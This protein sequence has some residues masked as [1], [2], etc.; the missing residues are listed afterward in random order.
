MSGSLRKSQE[1]TFV[2]SECFDVA[3]GENDQFVLLQTFQDFDQGSNLCEELADGQPAS[4][5]SEEEFELIIGFLETNLQ[6]SS[7]QRETND[8]VYIG[9]ISESN[10]VRPRTEDDV[11]R[12]SWI[13][14]SD[15][16][17]GTV[18]GESPWNIGEPNNFQGNNADG[19][20]G[21]QEGE[22]CVIILTKDLRWN[23]I[24]CSKQKQML[25]RRSCAVRELP[26]IPDSTMEGEGFPGGLIFLILLMIA[27]VMAAILIV[28]RAKKNRSGNSGLGNR[29]EIN[30]QFPRDDPSLPHQNGFKGKGNQVPSGLILPPESRDGQTKRSWMRKLVDT[31]TLS[32]MKPISGHENSTVSDAETRE[33][34][35]NSYVN[36]GNSFSHVPS[37][38]FSNRG[39]FFSILTFNTGSASGQNQQGEMEIGDPKFKGVSKFNHQVY[40]KNLRS[41]NNLKKK[42]PK[43]LRRARQSREFIDFKV[44]DSVAVRSARE[45]FKQLQEEEQRKQGNQSQGLTSSQQLPCLNQKHR[46]DNTNLTLTSSTI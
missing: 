37:T 23:D 21:N 8:G 14:G 42:K 3:S 29:F 11:N 35:A 15:F 40:L 7:E 16:V 45:N 1:E 4:I 20:Q 43:K 2:A 24:R 9:L 46:S 6:G 18:P 39:S 5:G 32:T 26:F 41:M 17:F 34:D 44:E 13:D 25:C 33:M 31:T 30:I 19:E 38:N 36:F 28:W 27:G 10:V 12:F 22:D